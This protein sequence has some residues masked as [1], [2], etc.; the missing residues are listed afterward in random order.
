MAIDFE[1]HQQKM[2]ESYEK[3]IYYTLAL[4]VSA[5]V[6]AVQK[7]NDKIFEWSLLPLGLALIS[8][9]ISFVYG[10]KWI[11]LK[12]DYYA[13]DTYKRILPQLKNEIS[14]DLN[15][16]EKKEFDQ[17]AK[18]ISSNTQEAGFK[19]RLRMGTKLNLYFF[20]LMFD[21]LSFLFWHIYEMAK[22]SSII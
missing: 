17:I 2:N 20:F 4:D 9:S 18:S 5:L 3:F 22:R 12:I 21:I 11:H 14:T 16:H 15:P 8:W 6:Y 19:S 7:T 1:E 10:I 13:Y